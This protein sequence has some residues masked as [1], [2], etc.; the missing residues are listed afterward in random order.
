[1]DSV[2]VACQAS[3]QTFRERLVEVDSRF[4][5]SFLIP[6]QNAKISCNVLLANEL[7][8]DMKKQ[9]F[10]L[11]YQNMADLYE[12]SKQGL[13]ATEKREELFDPLSRFVILTTASSSGTDPNLPE[14]VVPSSSSTTTETIESPNSRAILVAFAMFRFDWE[15]TMSDEDVEV[16]YCYELQIEKSFQ[17]FGLGRRLMDMLVQL[18]R[19]WKMRKCMLTVFKANTGA[20]AFYQKLGYRPD[21]IS[22]SQVDGAEEE[23]YEILSLLV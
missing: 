10:T 11:F 5:T 13:D 14:P 4:S 12:S 1:M 3:S 8:E 23:D 15:E 9:I 19:D 17:S 16:L 22:P 2:E 7:S 18:A 20:L 6:S 21:E